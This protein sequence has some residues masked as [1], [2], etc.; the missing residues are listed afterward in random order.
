MQTKLRSEAIL[1]K[2][3]AIA[4]AADKE[5]TENQYSVVDVVEMNFSLDWEDYEDEDDTEN[6]QFLKTEMKPELDK[7][8]AALQAMSDAI[9]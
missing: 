6:V 4:E 8:I 2:L 1:E 9:G 3:A 5:T 7:L